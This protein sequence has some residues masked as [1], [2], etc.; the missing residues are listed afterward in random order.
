MSNS[1]IDVLYTSRGEIELQE[2]YYRKIVVKD[3][4]GKEHLVRDYITPNLPLEN[5][6]TMLSLEMAEFRKR[7]LLPIEFQAP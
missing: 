6:Q 5:V 3:R 4:A 7:W 1:Q 2:H